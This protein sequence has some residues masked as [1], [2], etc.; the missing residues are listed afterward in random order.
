[1]SPD[2]TRQDL[3]GIIRQQGDGAREVVASIATQ[4]LL[5]SKVNGETMVIGRKIKNALKGVESRYNEVIF[6]EASIR[7]VSNG[8]IEAAAK[9]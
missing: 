9:S 7:E 4:S 8:M 1:M 3:Q 5:Q 6:L 2:V